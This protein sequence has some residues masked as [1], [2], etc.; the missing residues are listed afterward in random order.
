MYIYI[1]YDCV[2]LPISLEFQAAKFHGNRALCS[3]CLGDSRTERAHARC[4]HCVIVVYNNWRP[5][6]VSGASVRDGIFIVFLI[7]RIA[8]RCQAEMRPEL[9]AQTNKIK[10]NNSAIITNHEAGRAGSAE[11]LFPCLLQ[12]F[13]HLQVKMSRSLNSNLGPGWWWRSVLL[14]EW[15]CPVRTSNEVWCCDSA[16]LYLPADTKRNW[17]SPTQML[18]LILMCFYR[19][20]SSWPPGGAQIQIKGIQSNGC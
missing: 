4:G 3:V 9:W 14:F 8:F 1:L 6:F 18:V 11:F 15:C 16:A 5:V 19:M 12:I 20:I 7:S 2:T 13:K 17:F 10:W